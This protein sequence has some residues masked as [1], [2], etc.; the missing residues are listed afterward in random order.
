MSNC[1]QTSPSQPAVSRYETQLLEN[2]STIQRIVHAVCRRH[3]SAPDDAEEFMARV[4]FR[5]IDNEYAIFR[6]FRGQ[7][8]LATYLTVVISMFFRENRSAEWGRWR[9]SAAARRAGDLGVRL[10][11]LLMRDG[12]PMTQAAQSLRTAGRTF[13]SDRELARLASTFPRRAPTRSVA[14]DRPIPEAVASSRAD[15]RVDLLD[16][17]DEATALASAT[18]AALQALAPHERVIVRMHF[19]EGLTVAEV[20]RGLG[21][22]QKPLYRQLERARVKMRAH[23]ERSGISRE[24]ACRVAASTDA[25]A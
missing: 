20:A 2:L 18:R 3:G 9:V 22:P 10:E 8:S 13:L 24:Q 15:D 23:L 1:L 6:K 7:S 12:M 19:M 14:S 16:A 17:I 5:L 21:V 4:L 25:A 11:A